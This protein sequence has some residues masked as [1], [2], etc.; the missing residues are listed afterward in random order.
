LF[1]IPGPAPIDGS[2]AAAGAQMARVCGGNTLPNA[3]ANGSA[4]HWYLLRAFGTA[5]T[6][7]PDER[8]ANMGM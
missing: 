1:H 5:A 4:G 6:I 8:M 3:S 7:A 2:Y